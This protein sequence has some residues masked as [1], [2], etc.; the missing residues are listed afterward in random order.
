TLDD[1]TV[2]RL[3]HD[4][5]CRSLQQPGAGCAPGE[6]PGP[7]G[8]LL[9]AA[10]A[11]VPEEGPD[12][13]P[14]VHVL[15]V[16]SDAEEAGQLSA[17]LRAAGAGVRVCKDGP[18]G[19]ETFEALRPDLVLIDERVSRLKRGVQFGE[20]L[21]RTEAGRQTPVILMS[22]SQFEKRRR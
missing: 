7:R 20:L 8:L 16:D 15:I 13:K 1:G 4:P 18:S 14:N 10:R 2:H 9:P 6:S 21:K 3:R 19:L 11:Q 22:H 12:M 17:V 5:D